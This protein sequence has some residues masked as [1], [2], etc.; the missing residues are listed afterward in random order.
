MIFLT[1]TESTPKHFFRKKSPGN[2]YTT[3]QIAGIQWVESMVRQKINSEHTNTL[4]PK[5]NGLITAL[6]RFVRY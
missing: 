2:N 1:Q 3:T 5:H 4:L 6:D